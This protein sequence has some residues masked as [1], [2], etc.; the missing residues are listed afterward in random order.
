MKNPD[1]QLNK[2]KRGAS[3]IINEKELKEILAKSREAKRPLTVKAGF[4]PS[5]PDIHLGHSVLIRKM[6]HF[7]DLGHKVVFLIGDFTGRIGD[8]SGQSQTRK[9]LTEKEVRENAATYKK[10]VSK[11]LDMKKTEIRFNSE[12]CGKLGIDGIFELASKYTV[13]RLLERDDFSNRY[14]QGKPISVL[15]FL[16]P[17]I[18]GY[19]S[20]A[21]KADVELGG[22][23]QKF[24]LLVGREMQRQYSQRPQVVIT[25]PLLEGTDGVNKMSKSLDNYV[26]INENPKD[27]FGKLMSI[28]DE[29]MFKYYELLTDEDTGEIK[30]LVESGRLHPKNAKMK[31]AKIIVGMYHSES[32]ADREAEN[33]DRVF[34]SKGVP[35]DMPVFELEQEKTPLFKLLVV[36]GCADSSSA[37]RRLIKQNAVQINGKKISDVSFS[38]KASRKPAIIKSGKLKYVKVIK[39]KS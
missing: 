29:L 1:T 25:M 30:S 2:I 22:T 35:E 14:K 13:S 5:A 28:S 7:Q 27:M 10:Q 11:I 8:P 37:A 3:E 18:Q 38:F 12:W 16:Y 34:K 15:E 23:D 19:D 24:N 26:G 20:V 33:F 17:L 9:S 6:K 32:A 21:L 31:L 39:K 4:D 36:T